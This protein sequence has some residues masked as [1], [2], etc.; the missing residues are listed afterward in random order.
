MPA[1]RQG[2]QPCDHWRRVRGL[3]LHADDQP[4]AMRVCWRSR[5][6]PA[7]RSPGILGCPTWRRRRKGCTCSRTRATS[8]APL[9]LSGPVCLGQ[10]EP[11]LRALGKIDLGEEI[12]LDK[13]GRKGV[14]C[15]QASGGHPAF[16]V[17]SDGATKGRR[18]RR[19]IPRQ[20][21]VARSASACGMH[22]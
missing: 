4:R 18:Q 11:A 13:I 15:S 21:R 9:G 1:Q 17:F 14:K 12:D 7:A 5:T 6:R 16:P 8:S 2:G 10:V 20:R 3:R 19:R 22:G